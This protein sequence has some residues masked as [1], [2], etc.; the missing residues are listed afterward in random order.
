MALSIKDDA[1][2]ALARQLSKVTGES[3]TTA[4]RKAVQERLERERRRT[5]RHGLA[6]RLE[7]IAARGF[8]DLK[9]GPGSTDDDDLYDEDGL[10]R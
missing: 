9:P 10:P 1:T 8:G 6:E 5:A 4:V 7:A 2:D 3:L